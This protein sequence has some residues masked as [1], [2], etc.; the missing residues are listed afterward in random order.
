MNDAVYVCP[1]ECQA[2]VSQEDFDKGITKCGNETCS[3]KGVE[4]KKMVPCADCGKLEEDGK[5]EC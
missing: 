2:K 1:G 3:L 4:F 5:C